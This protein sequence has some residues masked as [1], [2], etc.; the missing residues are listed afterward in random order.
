MHSSVKRTQTETFHRN[1]SLVGTARKFGRAC[2]AGAALLSVGSSEARADCSL[3]PPS[4]VWSSPADGARDVALDAD[5]LLVTEGIDLARAELTLVDE[6]TERVVSTGSEFP[7]HF[8]LGEL[9]PERRYTVR[10]ESTH[11]AATELHFS[12][13]QR[14]VASAEGGLLLRSVSRASTPSVTP[15][16]DFCDAVLSADT[17]FDTGVP[18]VYGFEVDASPSPVS[19]GSLWVMATTAVDDER[20]LRLGPWFVTRPAACNTPIAFN[21]DPAHREYTIYNIGEGGVI[22]A[23]NSVRGTPD[24][25]PSPAPTRDML[26]ECGLAQSRAPSPPPAFVAVASALALALVLRRRE[27]RP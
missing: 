23:S 19:P 21:D 13:G 11:P 16:P 5:L 7:G 10:I 15:A 4:I 24:P 20:D 6:A 25:V 17:C 22:R 2:V 18:S 3:P 8:D 12:T 27:P 1:G 26:L 14:R 9:E